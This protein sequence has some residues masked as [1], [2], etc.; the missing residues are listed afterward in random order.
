VQFPNNALEHR[1]QLLDMITSDKVKSNAQLDAAL[2]FL[3]KLGP[4][5]LDLTQLEEAAGVGAVVTAEQIA[6]AVRDVVAANEETL[7]EQRYHA[8]LNILFAQTRRVVKWGEVAAVRAELEAQV[9][10][11]LGPKTEA[12]LAPL[13]KK[14]LKE[15][16][17][18]KKAEKAPRTAS[19]QDSTAN[20][21]S[22]A[23]IE[24]PAAASDPF[25]FLPK[26]ADNNIVHTTVSFSDG[27]Q[28][29][30][31]NTPEQLAAHLA[32]TGGR[33]VT[34]FP[35]EPNGYLHIG[36]AKAM[37]IDFG[38][39]AQSDGMCYLRFDDTNPEAEKQEYIDHILEIVSWLGWKPSKVTYSSDYFEQLYEMAVRLIQ[40]GHAYV[41]HQ[42]GS[43]IKE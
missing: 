42:T 12:D 38:M 34:R 22:T 10:A 43:E 20:G 15:A 29:H 2:E 41:C 1:K 7:V 6:A 9:A 36:H 4:T 16:K 30:I 37:F 28:M 39:A 31:S 13:E 8:N 32:R 27:S 3:G 19:G 18:E 23:G 40:S 17:K 33:I 25:A 21:A 24:Q 35:P 5:P 26:P 14:K 11:L